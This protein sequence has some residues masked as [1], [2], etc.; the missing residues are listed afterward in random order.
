M[1]M[2]RHPAGAAVAHD[3][4]ADAAHDRFVVGDDPA[5]AAAMLTEA[6]NKLVKLLAQQIAAKDHQAEK[7][8][9]A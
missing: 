4:A 3:E 8:V 6:V 1:P 9:S 5:R 2:A 7:A